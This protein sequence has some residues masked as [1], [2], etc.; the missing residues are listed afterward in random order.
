MT[1]AGNVSTSIP[2]NDRMVGALLDES[3]L[4]DAFVAL[5]PKLFGTLLSEPNLSDAYLRPC[6]A[7]GKF[8]IISSIRITGTIVMKVIFMMM[9]IITILVM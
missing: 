5:H 6:K 1:S 7:R 9:I 3:E 4:G 2:A 8:T